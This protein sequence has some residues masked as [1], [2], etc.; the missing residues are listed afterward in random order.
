MAGPSY[1]T[2]HLYTNITSDPLDNGFS[3]RLLYANIINS[4][5]KE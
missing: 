1:L 3:I 2:T 5:M 4:R